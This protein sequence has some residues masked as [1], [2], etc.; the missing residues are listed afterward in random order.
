MPA[1]PVKRPAAAIAARKKPAA[2]STPKRGGCPGSLEV[3]LVCCGVWMCVCVC[4]RVFL[5]VRTRACVCVR[6][7]LSVCL[8]GAVFMRLCVA[9]FALSCASAIVRAVDLS[10]PRDLPDVANAVRSQALAQPAA[11]RAAARTATWPAKES[12]VRRADSWPRRVVRRAAPRG[13]RGDRRGNCN[14]ADVLPQLCACVPT[15][16]FPTRLATNNNT[17]Q[18]HKQTHSTTQQHAQQHTRTHSA[19]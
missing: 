18:T 2:A 11:A 15:C 6:V 8:C 12:V 19:T 3:S 4:V 7:C 16:S 1:S 5:S 10:L 17:N 14:F 9:V 13:A